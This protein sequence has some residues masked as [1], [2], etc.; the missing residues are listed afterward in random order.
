[1]RSKREADCAETLFGGDEVVRR[2]SQPAIRFVKD[3]SDA[4]MLARSGPVPMR[5]S[6]RSF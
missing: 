5:G 1:M 2:F 6:G 3:P 4:V